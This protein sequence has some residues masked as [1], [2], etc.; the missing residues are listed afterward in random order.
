MSIIKLLNYFLPVIIIV[1]LERW[2]NMLI[3]FPLFPWIS[4]ISLPNLRGISSK[5]WV[6]DLTGG[7]VLPRWILFSYGESLHHFLH[8]SGERI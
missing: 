3:R 8:I 1:F 2:S 7:L 6:L 4:R 5:V